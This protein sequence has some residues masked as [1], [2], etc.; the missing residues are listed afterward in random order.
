MEKSWTDA[1]KKVLGESKSPLHYAEISEQI[2][3]RGYYATDG[4]TPAARSLSDYPA[5]RNRKNSG[6]SLL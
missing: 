2:L 6:I 4:A 5:R 1:I 3:S